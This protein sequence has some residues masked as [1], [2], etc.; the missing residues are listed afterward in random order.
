V[1]WGDATI[2][3]DLLEVIQQLETIRTPFID[4]LAAL[5]QEVAQKLNGLS[6]NGSEPPAEIK[7]RDV[8][9]YILSQLTNVELSSPPTAVRGSL[10]GTAGITI[11]LAIQKNGTFS[12]AQIEQMI[13]SL[14]AL[15]G[16]KYKAEMKVER[17]PREPQKA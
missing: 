10:K 9:F 15:Q 2:P 8:Q 6:A 17:Q 16:A 13:E 1:G 14:P 12:K 4:S 7:I 3:S 5:R 11:D